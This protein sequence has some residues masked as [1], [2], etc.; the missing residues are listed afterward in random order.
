[1]VNAEQIKGQMEVQGSDGKHIGTVDG[2]EGQRV[3]LAS[4]GM[5]HYIDLDMVDTIKDGAVRLNKTAA[6]ATRPWH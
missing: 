6:E 2:I 4:G 3:R 5:L 1:M